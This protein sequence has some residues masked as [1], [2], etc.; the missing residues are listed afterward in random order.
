MEG[1]QLRS[2]REKLGWTQEQM[3][4]EL[5]VAAN[6]IARWERGERGISESTAL[7]IR[8]LRRT[9][10]EKMKQTVIRLPCTR[11]IF[12]IFETEFVGVIPGISCE[13]LCISRGQCPRAGR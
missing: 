13:T 4:S 11:L 3:A 5:R 1:N 7:L 9:T 6:T 2:I 10:A 8:N 12:Q